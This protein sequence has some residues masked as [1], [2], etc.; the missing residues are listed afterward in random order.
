MW[1]APLASRPENCLVKE[2]LLRLDF[3]HVDADGSFPASVRTS[4]GP[5][6]NAGDT[7][8]SIDGEDKRRMVIV[9]VGELDDDG[10]MTVRL[11][12][13]RE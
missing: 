3:N 6:W 4:V 8:F 9:E 11:R 10:V 12:P 7:L 1:A 13:D 5:T 2:E